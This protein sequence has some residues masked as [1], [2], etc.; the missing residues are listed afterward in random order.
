MS[1]VN[2]STNMAKLLKVL[3][4]GILDFNNVSSISEAPTGGIRQTCTANYRK[5]WSLGANYYRDADAE[6]IILTDM[7]NAAPVGNV[8]DSTQGYRVDSFWHTVDGQR[9]LCTDSTAGGALWTPLNTPDTVYTFVL[10]SYFDNGLGTLDNNSGQFYNNSGSFSNTGGTFDNAS[11]TFDNNGTVTNNGSITNDGSII[12]TS[13]AYVFGTL[14]TSPTDWDAL[15]IT[16]PVNAESRYYH[17]GTSGAVI[18]IDLGFAGYEFEY[19]TGAVFYLSCDQMSSIATLNWT[20]WATLFSGSL[21]TALAGG[22][23]LEIRCI[24]YQLLTVR[25]Y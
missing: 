11:G 13:G 21:P 17:T 8:N 7:Q 2:L 14:H 18:Y 24:G 15:S 19:N 22:E 6:T 25:V 12:L 9:F 10:G 1:D 16:P 20:T 23:T 3:S 4:G 5:D